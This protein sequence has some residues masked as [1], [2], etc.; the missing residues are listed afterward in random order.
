MRFGIL[1]PLAVWTDA[2]DLVT[3]PELKTRA[4]LADLLVHAGRAVPAERLIDDL[5]GERLP[6]NPA[7][8][9]QGRV[10]ALRRAL[11]AAEPGGRALVA[12][13]PPGYVLQIAAEQLDASRFQDLLAEAQ[14]TGAA[15]ARAGLLADALALWRGSALAD[16]ADATFVRS[17]VI[18]LAE[19]RLVA[20]EERA[21]VRLE[22]GEDLLLVGE[23]SDLV[24]R[25]PLRERLRA[26]HMRALYRTGRQSEALASY[27]DLGQRL[28]D[29]LG[30]DPGAQVAALHQ[31]ILRQDPALEP[32]PA[33][34]SAP[35]PAVRGTS[36]PAPVTALVGRSSAVEEVAAL[37]RANRL[38]TLTG[39]GG[40]GKT[41][42]ALEVAARLA[43]SVADGVRLVELALAD[44]PAQGDQRAQ[45]GQPTG[46]GQASV[47]ELMTT[48][49]DIRDDARS[50]G[51][52]GRGHTGPSERLVG[53]LSDRQ[54]LL[55]LDNCEHVVGPVAELADRLL[56][57]APELR[58]LATS[59]EPLR[60]DGE[61]VWSVPPLGAPL[62]PT[63][64]DPATLGR[65]AA[66]RLFV[67][68]AA[69]AAP[70]FALDR[71]NAEAVATICRRLDGIPLGLELA[72][73][74]VPALGV[75]ELAARLDDR[76]RLLTAGR[77][78]A[79]PRQ[80]TL[81]AMID[82]SWELL[83][84][85]ERVLLRRLAAQA[86]SSTLAAIEAICADDRI[87]PGDI[88]ELVARLVDRSLVMVVDGPRGQ[89]GF[90]LLESVQAYC[91]E[92][93]QEAGEL[94][95][96]RARQLRFYTGLAER[97]DQHLRGP[98][99]RE[100]LDRL[101]GETANLRAALDGAALL[102]DA[103]RALRLGNALTWY[104]VLRGRLGE[105]H[106]SLGAAL[107]VPG[108]APAVL[109]ARAVVWR[110]ALAFG[111]GDQTD[112]ETQRGTVLSALDA[113]DD[114]LDRA[115]SEWTL[116]YCLTSV[117]TGA[118]T[119][120]A[121]LIERSLSA[122]RAL[123][124]RW[125]MA[126]ALA[127]RGSQAHRRK[128][129]A[130]ATRDSE[131]SMA[132]FR[133]LGDQWGQSMA[134]SNLGDLAILTGDYAQ[135]DRLHR[136]ALGIAEEMGLWVDASFVLSG[137]GRIALLT[138]DDASARGY[139]DRAL[140]LATDH[141]VTV[142]MELAE[143]GLGCVARR[144]ADLDRAE[145]HL[146]SWLEWNRGSRAY[147]RVAVILTE[148]GAVAGQRGHAEAALH[149]CHDGLA[150]ARASGN[151]WLVALATER[152]AAAYALAGRYGHA[153]RALGAADGVR[154][155]VGVP[156]PPSEQ[157]EL[158][159]VTAAV[160]TALG[161]DGFAAEFARAEVVAPE[162]R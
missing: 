57:A 54:L 29:E 142:A 92:R 52:S 100:W 126:A 17:Q 10:S 111:T 78:H 112:W 135:A 131:Q 25:Y 13:R 37:L 12:Y 84:R 47:P 72:A 36:L 38:V 132:W 129:I 34:A 64:V 33:P 154:A 140:R 11:E 30:I 59:Q 147:D 141:F 32:A 16:F 5:W 66:V 115:R 65:Y 51:P 144:E 1:G 3:V 133:E 122:F 48:A 113:L 105:L 67:A 159:L 81:R 90:K 93:L 46:G 23:L 102:P 18:S 97:A 123:G 150:A 83:E 124:D 138:G 134:A 6:D 42:L 60:V 137:L 73:A 117:G 162:L 40:V 143:V 148:L 31:A 45:G 157:H 2:G 76:F 96:T 160:R 127:V 114:P 119:A 151:R 109:R 63:E 61:V 104:W 136:T 87:E 68:R 58:I 149:L 69:A 56:A 75:H 15:R 55:V 94:L 80:Q 106:R 128:D 99:Q 91:L 98:E 62:D 35:A 120:G 88:P 95:A 108:P 103:T 50:T 44:Q 121:D 9:L 139:F 26:L 85:G 130:G 19:Q 28:R 20:L 110:A 14:A 8:A 156:A 155:S 146:R 24:D 145:E 43:T 41:R 49:L 161:D 118:E 7:N 22:L 116:G 21:E 53:A 74:R 107:A 153:A 101:D 158:A 77:R 152:L 125:G 82:W 89:R 39:P 4:L 79:P 70:G 86:G 71:G 27:R